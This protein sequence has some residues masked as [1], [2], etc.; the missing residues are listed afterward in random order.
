MEK[1]NWIWNQDP[2]SATV[3]Y[4]LYSQDLDHQHLKRKSIMEEVRGH[5]RSF[6]IIFMNTGISKKE[7]ISKKRSQRRGRS[8]V[9]VQLGSLSGT[10][11]VCCKS[12]C[13]LHL[14]LSKYQS[15]KKAAGLFYH[16]ASG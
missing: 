8:D 3:K 16:S 4:L 1:S 11:S 7:R 10:F 2:K 9:P 15:D 6:L 13:T 14:P 5:R 12:A